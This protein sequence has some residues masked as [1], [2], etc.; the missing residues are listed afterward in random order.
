[1]RLSTSH[2]VIRSYENGSHSVKSVGPDLLFSG[3]NSIEW[4]L[5]IHKLFIDIG[6]IN[7]ITNRMMIT[8]SEKVT[9]TFSSNQMHI[10]DDAMQSHNSRSIVYFTENFQF[11]EFKY[12]FN[13][14]YLNAIET[15][16]KQNFQ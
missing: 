13:R 15:L 5:V 16:E 11:D 8:G 14:L 7:R 9:W 2:H 4:H 6:K 10:T 3:K 1:M 12:S